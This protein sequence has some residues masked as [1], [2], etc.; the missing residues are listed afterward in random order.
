MSGDDFVL[1]ADTGVSAEQI[2]QLLQE[3]SLLR[4]DVFAQLATVDPAAFTVRFAPNDKASSAYF[5]FGVSVATGSWHLIPDVV[6]GASG[7]VAAAPGRSSV[8]VITVASRSGSTR[9]N[10]VPDSFR[11]GRPARGPT[12]GDT[13]TAASR[14]PSPAATSPSGP[15]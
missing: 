10:S 5:A 2:L 3:R 6:G 7:V 8:R 1:S 9:D 4:L 12:Q 14:R 11:M 15:V 13:P